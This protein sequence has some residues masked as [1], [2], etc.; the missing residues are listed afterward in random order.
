V[1]ENCP[2]LE[3]LNIENNNLTNITFVDVCGNLRLLDISD[4]AFMVNFTLDLQNTPN[5]VQVDIHGNNG[6]NER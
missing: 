2:N 6:I 3:V 1:I 4:N 5:L